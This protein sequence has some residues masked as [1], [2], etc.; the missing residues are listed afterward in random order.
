MS[1]LL[2][3]DDERVVTRG[4]EEDL[5]Q[6]GY[7]VVGVASSGEEAI[8]KARSLHP[9]LVLMDIVMPGAKDGIVAATEINA[10]LN[11]PVVFLTAYSDLELVERA[12]WSGAFGYIVKPAQP[13]QLR[14]TIE[15]TLHKIT[16]EILMR[17]LIKEQSESLRELRQELDE[18]KR[19]EEERN[20]S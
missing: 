10:E 7:E 13:Q 6:M 14:A 18:L 8:V 4:L 1:R 3:V 2:I 12:K 11:I 5:T 16:N 17:N 19:S 9:D 15:M 20:G